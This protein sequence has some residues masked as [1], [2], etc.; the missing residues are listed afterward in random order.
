MRGRGTNRFPAVIS[1]DRDG[2]LPITVRVEDPVAQKLLGT[3]VEFSACECQK[4]IS[5]ELTFD[6]VVKM[7]QEDMFEDGWIRG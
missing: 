4:D 3:F 2:D 6:K 7:I 1:L 5:N